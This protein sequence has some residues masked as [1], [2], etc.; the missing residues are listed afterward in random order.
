MSSDKRRLYYSLQ[1]RLAQVG[2]KALYLRKGSIFYTA[3]RKTRFYRELR[4]KLKNF[5]HLSPCRM[6]VAKLNIVNR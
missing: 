6:V 5:G 2:T 4:V 3:R 1:A